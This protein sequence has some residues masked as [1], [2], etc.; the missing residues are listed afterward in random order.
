MKFRIKAIN[1]GSKTIFYPQQFKEIK[2]MN[3]TLFGWWDYLRDEYSAYGNDHSIPIEC[4]SQE[5]AE[6]VINQHSLPVWEYFIDV[7][8]TK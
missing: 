7:S 4:S 2:I 5:E 1:N 8:R 6:K 3:F